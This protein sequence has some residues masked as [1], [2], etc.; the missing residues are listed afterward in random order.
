MEA[1]TWIDPIVEEVRAARE[2]LFREA[3]YDL[4]QLHERIVQSQ[5]RHRERL[6]RSPARPVPG[7]VAPPDVGTM[8]K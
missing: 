8:R 3:A 5:E 2:E 1:N 7:K 4:S 6:V